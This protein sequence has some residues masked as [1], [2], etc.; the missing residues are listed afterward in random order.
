MARRG[1]DE[2]APVR[3]PHR[4]VVVP[5]AVRQ[6]AGFAVAG[7]RDDKHVSPAVVD[8]SRAI[9]FVLHGGDDASRL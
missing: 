4:L 2:R 3:R 7:G 8:K 5:I 1:E 9:E 6:L